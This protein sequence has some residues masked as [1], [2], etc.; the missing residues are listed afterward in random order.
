MMKTKLLTL[1]LLS[2]PAL[3]LAT[4]CNGLLITLTKST[5]PH[6]KDIPITN[7][8]IGG[9]I[10]LKHSEFNQLSDQHYCLS[11]CTS[12][13]SGCVT[14]V[15]FSSNPRQNTLWN[16]VTSFYPASS[17]LKATVA[18]NGFNKDVHCPL[19][20]PGRCTITY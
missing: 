19:L 4:D 7:A 5:I 15:Q 2:L 20:S 17:T 13:G 16:V 9:G 11:H 3:S 12:T 14:R 1:S 8:S 10:I 6:I 18:V